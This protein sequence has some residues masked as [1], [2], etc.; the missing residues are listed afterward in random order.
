MKPG[1]LRCWPSGT[2]F[3]VLAYDGCDVIILDSDGLQYVING[4][5]VEEWSEA[6]DEDAP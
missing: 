6:I 2:A 4:K 3:L 1:D 5:E